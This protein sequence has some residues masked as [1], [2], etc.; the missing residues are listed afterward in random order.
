MQGNSLAFNFQYAIS[1]LIY[2]NKKGAQHAAPLQLETRISQL[3]TI[4][5]QA[6]GLRLI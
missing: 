6:D 2:S 1:I 5:Q 3:G 4:R